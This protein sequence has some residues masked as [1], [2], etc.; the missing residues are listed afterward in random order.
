MAG[1]ENEVL[2][3]NPSKPGQKDIAKKEPQLLLRRQ[4]YCSTSKMGLASVCDCNEKKPD[5]IDRNQW[6]IEG[7]RQWMIC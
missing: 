5:K 3:E 6:V 4:N 2:G 7:A 1:D